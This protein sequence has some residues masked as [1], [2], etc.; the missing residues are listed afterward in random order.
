MRYILAL[1]AAGLLLGAL[2]VPVNAQLSVNINFNIDRQPIWGPT[3]YDHVDYYYLPDIDVYYYVP[4][5][6]YYYIEKERWVSGSSLP[7]RYRGF[8]LYN[9]YK[10]VVNEPTPYRDDK[11]N[12]EKY[13]SYKGRHDQE[14]IRDSRDPKYFVNPKHPEHKNW[15]KQNKQGKNNNRGNSN[16]QGNRNGNGNDHG[17]NSGR[18]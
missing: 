1:I 7:S 18:K 4:Q 11:I 6:R 15:I 10:V 8:D 3:G 9:S 13:S 16:D 14:S 12:R 2:N 5:H 17:D